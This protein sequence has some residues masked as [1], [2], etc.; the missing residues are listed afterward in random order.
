MLDPRR[1]ELPPERLRWRCDPDTLGFDT[2]DDV[3]GGADI[4]GQ[5]RALDAIRLGLEIRSHGYNIFVTGLTGTGRTSS[6]RRL[7]ESLDRRRDDL[8]DVA[9][10]QHFRRPDEPRCLVFPAGRACA[11]RSRMGD[12]FESVRSWIPEVLRSDPFRRRQAKA[13]AELR[14]RRERMVTVFEREVAERGFQLVETGPEGARR[15]ALAPVVGGK[16]VDMDELPRLMVQGKL[17]R[18]DYEKLNAAWPE[19][20]DRLEQLLVQTREIEREIDARVRKLEREHV[21]PILRRLLDRVARDFRDD[22]VRAYL[23]ELQG[24]ILDNLRAF[25]EAGVEIPEAVLK[26]P[27]E[28]NVIVDN[29]GTRDAPVVIER[30]PTFVNLFGTIERIADG[31]RDGSVDFT[32]I[33]SGSLHRANGGYLV[34]NLTDVLEE[35]HV[36]TTLKRALKNREHQIRGFDTLLLAPVASLKPEPIALDVKVVLIGD[37]ELYALLY[38]WDDD[39]RRIFRV[40]AEFDTVMPRRRANIRRYARFLRRLAEDEGLPPFHRTAVAALVEEGVRLAGRRDRLSTRLGDIG[41]IAREAAYWARRARARTVRA[42]HV[43]RSVEQR[44][45]RANLGE[46]KLQELFEDGTIL[47]STRGRRVGQVNGLAVYD[48]GDHVFG[49]PSRITASVGVGRSGVINIER[50]AELSGRIHNKGVL[51]LEG[52]LRQMYAVDKPITMSASICFEQAYSG[53]DG[54]SASSTEVY[55]LLSSIAGIPLRQD[56]AVT[57]SVSQKGEIQPIGGVNEKIEGFFDVCRAHGLTGTQGVLIPWLNRGDLMLRSDVVDAV[58]AGRFHVYAVRT[59]DQGIELLTGMPSG[60]RLRSGRFTRG[61]VHAAVDA[62]LREF[63][64]R[65]RRA[66][67]GGDADARSDDRRRR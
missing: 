25:T 20:M 48:T 6:I 7:L 58:R 33:R 49:R 8:V 42:V 32:S 53:V 27:F 34:L 31:S 64:E 43:R 12:V 16:P 65:L 5:D 9:F 3:R 38:E 29:T 13:V 61:S 40:K 30:S 14:R 19:L 28:V 39:F 2:T 51:I 52:Y 60:R 41:D 54:D 36:Y 23:D 59:I 24:F 47:V 22:R 18:G 67:D 56:L 4:I 10:V 35:P 21:E 62:A 26:R 37:A 11:F 50:E 15:P 44:V 55:A 45:R 66:E 1:V 17:G 63:H 46:E 57:G